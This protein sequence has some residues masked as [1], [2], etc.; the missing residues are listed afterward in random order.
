MAGKQHTINLPGDTQ[1][2]VPA[3]ASEDTLERMLLMTQNSNKLADRML[4]GAE[5]ITEIDE[6]LVE[7]VQSNIKT[8]IENAKTNEAEVKG[9]ANVLIKG[10]QAIKDTAGFFGDSEKPLTSMVSAAEGLVKKLQGPQGK[11]GLDKLTSK[12]PPFGKFLKGYGGQIAG[13]ATDIVLALAG[14]NAAKFEQFAEV[15]KMMIDSGAI[16]YDTADV[17]DQLYK[18]SFQAGYGA[19]IFLS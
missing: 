5:A 10:A 3:W 1:V 19:L 9:K 15:Q 16:V 11:G 14:W 17:F 8:G 12:F 18:D 13:V 2:Q 6:E 7:A 4:K